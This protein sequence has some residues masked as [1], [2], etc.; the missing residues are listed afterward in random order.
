MNKKTIILFLTLFT[1]LVAGM[2][3]FANLRL[4]ESV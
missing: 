1:L 3:I 2:I 4:A